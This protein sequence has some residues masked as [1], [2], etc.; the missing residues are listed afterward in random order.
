MTPDTTPSLRQLRHFLAILQAGSLS[1]AARDVH[2]SQPSLS[3]SLATLERSIGAVLVARGRD[4]A[5]PTAA[6]DIMRLRAGR[7]FEQI[8]AAITDGGAEHAARIP[9]ELTNAQLRAVIAVAEA[10]SFQEAAAR[11][12]VAVPSLHRAAREL[13]A[14][15]KRALYRRAATGMAATPATQEL[16]RRIKVALREI[17]YARDDIDTLR[18]LRQG[19]LHVGV[20]PLFAS[21][22]LASS[23]RRFSDSA[24]AASVVVLEG[25]YEA[26][27]QYLRNG[28]LD[29]IFGVLRLPAWMKDLEERRLYDDPYCV[30]ARRGHAL[31]ARPAPLELAELMAFPWVVPLAG[32]PRRAACEQMFQA[33]G[34]VPRIFAETNSLTLQRALIAETDA[35]TILSGQEAKAEARR[36]NFVALACQGLPRRRHDGITTRRDWQPTALHERFIATLAEGAAPPPLA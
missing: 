14:V 24:P 12:G 20:I 29:F 27:L 1:R 8:G 25:P 22:L 36:G 19:Q 18:G 6:G 32:T 34:V 28:S 33:V 23:I 26:L 9:H 21:T 5:F 3:Q 17:D 15:L 2:V 30:A 31:A 13:E 7:L 10:G 35:L 11:L 16:A 4:G